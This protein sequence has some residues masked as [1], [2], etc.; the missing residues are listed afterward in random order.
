MGKIYLFKKMVFYG[1]FILFL[2]FSSIGY[3]QSV[4]RQCISSFGSSSYSGNVLIQQTSGQ[5]FSTYSTDNQT[6]LFQGFHQPVTAVAKATD[7]LPASGPDIKIYPNPASDYI[8]I[9]SNDVIDFALIKVADING[10]IISQEKVPQLSDHEI[11][12]GLWDNGV[13]FII[14]TNEEKTIKT[15][16][17]IISK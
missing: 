3:G 10:R 12:C 1:F 6:I 11:E 15:L 13:Y 14:I 16:K 4:K 2:W 9:Q 17:V 5:S 7:A 8:K